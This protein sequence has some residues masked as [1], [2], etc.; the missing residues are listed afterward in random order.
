MSQP[1]TGAPAAGMGRRKFLGYLIGGTG[2]VAA[3]NV[4][5]LGSLGE[6]NAL[7]APVPADLLDLNDV[8]TE[9]AL[10]TS[11]LI[12]VEVH[13]DGTASF[14][15][16]RAEV[17]QGIT[18]SIA[19]IIAEELELPLE[20]VRVTLAPARPELLFNQLTGGSNTI[21]AMYTP[22]R[23]AAALA[24]QALLEAAAVLLGDT[25]GSLT[26]KAGEIIGSTGRVLPYGELV[27]KAAVPAT[28]AREVEL[29]P[30]S[31]FRVVGTPQNRKDAYAAVTGQKQFA[32]D[33]EVE[34][35]LPAMVCRPPTI[36]GSAAS[37]L[38]SAEV[39]AMNGVTHVEIVP[40]GVA[41]RAHTFGQCIDAIRA[42][43]VQWKPGTAEGASDDS[44][45]AEIKSA[46][47]P[48]VVPHLPALAETMDFDF[49]FYFRSGS[50][51]E[52]NSAVA[53][54][55][56]DR[57]TIWASAKSPIAA[58]QEIAATL[59]IPSGKV[60]FNVV[61]GGGSFGRK[62]FFDG[63]LEA[64][65]VSRACRAPVRLMW[66]RADEPRQ[67]RSHPMV[68]A[69]IRV[70]H[71]GDQ[72]L[73]FEHRHTG[74]AVDFTHG[75]GEAITATAGKLPIA[76][77]LSLAETIFETTQFMPYDFG[78][79]NQ[80]LMETGAHDRFP[81]SAVRNV[82]SPDVRAAN[83]LVVDQIAKK[84]G[85]DP[86]EFRLAYLRKERVKRVLQKVAEA[87]EWG[88][89]MPPGTAQ[90]IAIHEEYKGVSA[91]LVE[92]DCRPETV[93]RQVRDAVT[94]PL[95]TKVTFAIDP[96]L[97]INPRGV[98]AQMQGGI[99]DGIALAL[100]NSSH[101]A[102]GRFLEASWDNSAY[103]RQWNTPREMRVF[104]MPS[105]NPPGGAG[106][107][108]VASAFAATACAYTR[109]VGKLP[110]YFPINHHD[111]LHFEPKSFI[112]PVPASPT[113]GLDHTY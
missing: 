77:N 57:A 42:L 34:G 100:T 26:A 21:F 111:P 85:K 5:L 84:L 70:A 1:G 39:K 99:S 106:E 74:V 98:E 23:V 30:E 44:I 104:V 9:A 75:L 96:G 76:G 60:T 86:Y 109:A 113:D 56:E 28:T 62:L 14:E 4:G 51:L 12:K 52:P 73:G 36:G 94:G 61:E 15:L 88:R 19:M 46:E 49:T 93:N 33:L 50:P 16:P 54:V 22:V 18:T 78:V 71:L 24:K 87:G 69:R 29:K 8:L 31:E 27:P 10:P 108:G 11:Q 53:D 37:V 43:R 48:M 47:L 6:A 105:D 58:K 79:I 32:M 72:V 40:S 89:S 91:C 2:L 59:G 97:V 17:G 55:R 68:T 63:A 45:R 82:Y 41:V 83:E 66:H 112:P 35:A 7:T 81:T 64:A 102:D 67:G 110:Q 80:K 38:N 3:A 95:V 103:T 25:I 92:I 107:A 13:E 20:K 101:L 65:I 90:G